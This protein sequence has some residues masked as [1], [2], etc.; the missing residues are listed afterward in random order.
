MAM[1]QVALRLAPT[2]A[3]ALTFAVLKPPATAVL[4][5]VLLAKGAGPTEVEALGDR[6]VGFVRP[7]PVVR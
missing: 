1:E 7:P 6:L 5:G 2:L 4:K 3:F